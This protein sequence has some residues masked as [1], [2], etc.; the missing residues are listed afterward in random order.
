MPNF[1]NF[2]RSGGT[3]TAKGHCPAEEDT[4]TQEIQWGH[5]FDAAVQSALAGGKLVLVDFSAAPL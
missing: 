4:M 5:D 3:V 1:T 2:S